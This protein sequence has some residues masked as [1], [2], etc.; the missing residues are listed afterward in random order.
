MSTLHLLVP[1]FTPTASARRAEVEH[2]LQANLSLPA[3]TQLHLLIDDGHTPPLGSAAAPEL[4]PQ[5]VWLQQRPTFR[6]ALE[7]GLRH[8]QLD[9]LLLIANSD[10]QFPV[11][12]AVDLQRELPTDRP[13]LLC[14]TR[15]N[16]LPSGALSLQHPPH[17]SQ[18]AWAL[19]AS[20]AAQLTPE[21]LG[22]A[23][24]PFGVPRCDNRIPYIFFCRGWWLYNP[25]RRIQLIHNHAS[26]LRSYASTC[27]RLL[28]GG[29]YV[30]LNDAPLQP[31][32]LEIATASLSSQPVSHQRIQRHL[33]VIQA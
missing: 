4:E 23:A 15:T 22:E 28:G 10:I 11:S 31:S 29:C 21:L 24:I 18:D 3:A 32:A 12:I 27:T 7:Q 33:E 8:A 13:A 14:L 6:D 17:W 19:R 25:S 2:T 20:F 26:G 5:L 1:Y 30:H 9:D 16:R